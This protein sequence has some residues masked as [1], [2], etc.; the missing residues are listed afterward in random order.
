MTG[1]D[2]VVV[3]VLVSVLVV[4]VA[5]VAI[6]ETVQTTLRPYRDSVPYLPKSVAA[7]VAPLAPPATRTFPV[8]LVVTWVDGTDNEWRRG[9]RAMRTALKSLGA[10]V[11]HEAKRDPVADASGRDELSYGIYGMLAHLPFL[12]H[13]YIVTER[14]HKPAWFGT[15]GSTEKLRLIHHDEFFSDAAHL[16]TRNSDVIESQLHRIPGLA[17]HVILANDDFFVGQRLRRSDFFT[18]EGVPVIRSKLTGRLHRYDT[19][20]LF[21]RYLRNLAT[22]ARA[23]GARDPLF[24]PAHVMLPTL[25]SNYTE[26]VRLAQVEIGRFLPFRSTWGFP[27]PYL[28]AACTERRELDRSVRVEYYETGDDFARR[29]RDTGKPLPH[30]FC[31]NSGFNDRCRAILDAHV[32]RLHGSPFLRE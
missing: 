9:T 3:A 10:P 20:D 25:R 18:D 23:L 6:P 12:R 27:V 29:C 15:V 1:S 17:E 24:R 4:A 14:P 21:A 8:D 31:I 16:P 19:N 5:T 32:R 13:I 30:L 22:V 7:P 26:V 2:A 28:V 11:S